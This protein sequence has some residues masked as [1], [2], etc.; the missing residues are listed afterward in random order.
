M[1]EKVACA[2]NCIARK[3]NKRELLRGLGEPKQADAGDKKASL[4]SPCSDDFLHM[5]HP[6]ELTTFDKVL[7]YKFML[8]MEISDE[9]NEKDKRRSES[10]V[11]AHLTSATSS[12][13]ISGLARVNEESFSDFEQADQQG[14]TKEDTRSYR[15]MSAPD[16]GEEVS[17]QPQFSRRLR[18]S[19]RQ[20]T[21]DYQDD[22][23]SISGSDPHRASRS[24]LADAL[25]NMEVMDLQHSR[26]L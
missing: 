13:S 15:S 19:A 8:P 2:C 9:M 24:A 23:T 3:E 4:R 1:E 22:H 25:T 18:D 11:V 14:Q 17:T 26:I 6:E 21:L 16:I 10:S 5:Y 12:S 20:H 7:G